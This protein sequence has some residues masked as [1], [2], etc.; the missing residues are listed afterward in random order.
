MII[1]HFSFWQLNCNFSHDR[2]IKKIKLPPKR[3]LTK[4]IIQAVT[5]RLAK[6]HFFIKNSYMWKK[7]FFQK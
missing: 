7:Y 6:C 3:N 5:P 4:V 1:K 2:K